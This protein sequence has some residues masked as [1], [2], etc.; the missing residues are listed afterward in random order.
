MSD[1]TPTPDQLAAAADQLRA[2]PA[3]G[4]TPPDETSLAAELAARQ[5]AAPA[6]VTDVDVAKLLELIQ[7]MQARVD[8]LEAEK[9]SGAAV[10][11]LGT[12]EALRDLIAVHAAHSPG[13]D[14]GDVLRLA[15]DAVDAA[16]NAADTG[17]G[18]LVVQISQK[19]A[20]ALAKVH[21]GGGD[22][23]Y[24]RQALGFAEVHLPDAAA[25]LVP[26]PAK[27]SA[28]L[29]STRGS[30]PVLQGSVTG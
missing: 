20:R 10:P 14:H 4:V 5:A 6:G 27:P 21:P 2:K 11:V 25:Q 17:D 7:G 3:P 26:R 1:P 29:T 28:E 18:S 22:H 8:A 12:A 23:H 30:V 15:D 13:A 24:F 19:I 9:A 16:R